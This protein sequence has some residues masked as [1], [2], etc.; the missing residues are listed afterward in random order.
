MTY[1]SGVNNKRQILNPREIEYM[2]I[3]VTTH[4]TK[5]SQPWSVLTGFFVTGIKR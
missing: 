4:I 1:T 2:F 5:V 3:L